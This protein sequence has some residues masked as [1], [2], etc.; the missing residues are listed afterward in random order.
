M[1][2]VKGNFPFTERKKMTTVYFA[3]YSDNKQGT[4]KKNELQ[5]HKTEN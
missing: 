4:L 1:E 3:I 2:I 5:V